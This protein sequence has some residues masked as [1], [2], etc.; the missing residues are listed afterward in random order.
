MLLKDFLYRVTVDQEEDDFR[1]TYHVWTI[2]GLGKEISAIR[3][4]ESAGRVALAPFPY[5]EN[6]GDF[7]LSMVAGAGLEPATYSL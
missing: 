4:P 6:K 2:P 7:R 1:A 3:Q 5:M